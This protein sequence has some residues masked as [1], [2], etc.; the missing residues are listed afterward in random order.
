MYYQSLELKQSHSLGC[1]KIWYTW[2]SVMICVQFLC[3]YVCFFNSH[4]KACWHFTAPSRRWH[5]G[6][7][8]G[9]AWAESGGYFSADRGGAALPAYRKRSS[10]ARGEQLSIVIYIHTGCLKS[11]L[12][13]SN[14][15][16]TNS[17]IFRKQ[18]TKVQGNTFMP[19][20]SKKTPSYC[21]KCQVIH[22]YWSREFSSVYF[23]A[24]QLG[25]ET[26]K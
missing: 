19:G 5:C 8:T 24:H 7:K 21:E 15:A 25:S 1:H 14:H 6:C 20:S 3:V 9:P 17:S 2:T 23:S 16:S 22:K 13:G 10:C 18:P 11:L 26:H 12:T 4:H